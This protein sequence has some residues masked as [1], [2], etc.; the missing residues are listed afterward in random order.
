MIGGLGPL[1]MF[2]LLLGLPFIYLGYK[3]L[4][5]SK[6]HEDKL[7]IARLNHSK[8][9]NEAANHESIDR[10]SI[11]S[12]HDKAESASQIEKP[13]TIVQNITYN[14]HDSAI[15]GDISNKIK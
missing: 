9:N 15:S 10:K 6:N 5:T 7:N 2:I 13:T 12:I 11:K 4:G 1:E 8:H 14:I 3:G